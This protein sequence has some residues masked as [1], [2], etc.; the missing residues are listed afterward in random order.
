[1]SRLCVEIFSSR[2]IEKLSRGTLLC[3][4][5]FPVSKT[6]WKRGG[7]GGREGVSGFSVENFLSPVSKNFLGGPF[8]ASFIPGIGKC[9]V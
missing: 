4:T 9:Q 6:L 8:S 2:K 7:E 3:F 5:K 1:M